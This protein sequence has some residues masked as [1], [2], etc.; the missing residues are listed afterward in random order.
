LESGLC[1]SKSSL[2]QSSS[3]RKHLLSLKN[4]AVRDSSGKERYQLVCRRGRFAPRSLINGSIPLHCLA[5]LQQ[6][7]Y[8]CVRV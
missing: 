4:P 7:G 8:P 5:A 1:V 2:I 6:T 3:L